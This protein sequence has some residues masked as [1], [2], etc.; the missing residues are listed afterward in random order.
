MKLLPIILIVLTCIFCVPAAQ[1]ATIFSDNFNG[2][3]GGVGALN[4]NTF[5]K[6]TVSNGAVDLIGVGGVF[7]FYPGNGLYV[8]LDGTVSKAGLL[9]STALSLA[10]GTYTLQ[11][12][13][14]GS[15][16]GDTNTVQVALGTFYNEIFTLNSSDPLGV[17]TR[18]VTVGTPGTASLT[19]QNNGTDNMG[20]ILD[21]VSI[22]SKDVPSVP[23]TSSLTLLAMGLA[24]VG[25]LRRTVLNL[26]SSL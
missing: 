4:Y 6:W 16:R 5:S 11:F 12:S 17:I 8:D 15:R 19:F 3:N 22:D 2:E 21:N 13:L 23:E 18:T 14:G 7:D 10:T 24:S 9:S 1:A 20:A 26:R 25:L